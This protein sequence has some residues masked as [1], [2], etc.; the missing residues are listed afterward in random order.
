MNNSTDL[1]AIEQRLAAIEQK[2]SQQN[3]QLVRQA[4]ELMQL[5]QWQQGHAFSYIAKQ[6]PKTRSVIFLHADFFA[7]NVKYA[8]LAFRRLAQKQNIDCHFLINNTEQRAKMAGQ[9]LPVLPPM[10]EWAL[11]HLR[12]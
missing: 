7:D 4:R 5:N 2:L 11:D 1:A 8:F 10:Q 3:E 6:H 9:G 12:L